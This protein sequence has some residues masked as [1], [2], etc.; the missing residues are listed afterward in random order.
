MKC[1]YKFKID[2]VINSNI[3]FPIEIDNYEYNFIVNN[4]NIDYITVTINNICFDKLPTFIRYENPINKITGEFINTNPEFDKIKDNLKI[5]QGILSLFG[6]LNINLNEYEIDWI[7]ENED[8]KKQI[9]L[10]N[11]KSK[12][13]DSFFQDVPFDLLAKCILF[14]EKIKDYSTQLNL[15]RR[16][17]NDMR[18]EFY[19]QAYNNFY[20][21]IESFYANGKF[22]RNDVTEEFLKSEELNKITNKIINENNI[23]LDLKAFYKKIID[24]RGF[25]H[26]HSSQKKEMWHPEYQEKH[27]EDAKILML[28]SYK[29]LFDKISLY[30]EDKSIIE[31]Y[32][33]IYFKYNK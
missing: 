17:F 12:H 21:I 5:I 28:I 20:L 10:N 25:F 19:I 7:A 8:E 27:I 6:V 15:F 24:K 9:S 31:K 11:I 26:H 13:S 32:E 3:L 2:S 23:Y 4:S 14:S 22:R 33:N 16:G 29:I 1:L 30:I 18:N